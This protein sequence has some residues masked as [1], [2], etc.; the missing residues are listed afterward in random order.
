MHACTHTE[1]QAY[2]YTLTNTHTY[3]TIHA[4]T[5]TLRLGD[6]TIFIHYHDVLLYYCDSGKI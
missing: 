6:S 1:M 5:Y 4:C 2:I 3:T